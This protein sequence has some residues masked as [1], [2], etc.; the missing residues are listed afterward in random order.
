MDFNDPD[1]AFTDE[2]R[3]AS[4]DYIIVV[5]P[6]K[7][8]VEFIPTKELAYQVVN[9]KTHVIEAEGSQLWQAIDALADLQ[10]AL[11]HSRSG[12]HS[13]AG[14]LEDAFN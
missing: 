11:D 6:F 4:K 3:A 14:G 13:Q 2:P 12:V 8:R 5:S 9:R 1:I 10:K 7:V